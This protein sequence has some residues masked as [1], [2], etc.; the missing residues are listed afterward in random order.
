MESQ[1]AATRSG[2]TQSLSS[3][4][5]FQ[6]EELFRGEVCDAEIERLVAIAKQN[7]CNVLAASGGGKAID[8]VKAAAAELKL[9]AVVIP[10][11]AATDAPCSALSVIYKENGEFDRLWILP[12]NP[13]L[14]LVDTEII[15]QAPVRLLVAGMGDAL[16]TWFEAEACYNSGALNIS[17]GKMTASALA[18]A[19]LCYDI[20]L[21]YGLQAKI[22]CE[23]KL[24]T[25][26]LEKVVEANTLLSG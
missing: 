10:T 2:R 15:C 22:A 13:D 3:Q 18:L 8:A 25:P 11:T 21:E 1:A 9:P 4:G 14:V 20:L 19:R 12:K 24:V 17:G 5:I 23:S 16:A 7:A 6:V 26:A